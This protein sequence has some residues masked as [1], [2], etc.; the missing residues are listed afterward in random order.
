MSPGTKVILGASTKGNDVSRWTGSE[1]YIKDGV[2][3]LSPAKTAVEPTQRDNGE[4]YSASDFRNALGAAVENPGAIAEFVGEENVEAVL[5]ILDLTNDIE[6]TSAM[7]GG[8]MA[9][10]SVP[11]GSTSGKRR[12][13]APQNTMIRHENIDLSIIDEVMELI[14]KRGII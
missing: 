7:G 2:E 1:K 6:E 14:T 3:L 12:K 10:A 11:L 4:P 13:K 9:G 5:R 8:A